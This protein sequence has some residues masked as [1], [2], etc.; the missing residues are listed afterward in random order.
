MRR[1]RQF[2]FQ[3]AAD[4]GA[5]AASPFKLAEVNDKTLQVTEQDKP[6]LAY[7]YGTITGENVPENDRGDSGPA[8]CIR[9][10]AW[11][12]KC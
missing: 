6:V 8:T 1:P 10:G 12:A 7:N 11:T 4:S 9:S 3:R 5:P 2:R